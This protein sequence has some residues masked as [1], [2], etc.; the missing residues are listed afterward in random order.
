MP[1]SMPRSIPRAFTLIE[2]LVVISIIAL[3]IALLLPALQQARESGRSVQCMSNLRQ[4][5]LANVSYLNDNDDYMTP[6]WNR[7]SNKTFEALLE[8]YL[9]K[10]PSPKEGQPIVYCPTNEA[11]GNPPA[12]GFPSTGLKGWS[13]YS[14][15]YLLNAQ[16][17]GAVTIPSYNMQP[18]RI[19]EVL[20]PSLVLQINDIKPRGPK[21]QPPVSGMYSLIYFDPA[22]WLVLGT[23]HSKAGNVLFVDGHVESFR[24]DKVLPVCSRRDQRTVYSDQ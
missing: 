24:G 5:D 20:A 17:H 15:G 18:V 19:T 12:G 2:L 1:R 4:I 14:F 7:D 16:V 22:G 10:K 13:G 6:F 23:P 11:N 8:P 9:G 3:L 21:Y